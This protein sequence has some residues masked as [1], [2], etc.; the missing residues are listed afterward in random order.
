MA[1]TKA[2][3][4][5]RVDSLVH[6]HLRIEA[7][8]RNST[9]NGVLRRDLGLEEV[10]NQLPSDEAAK[11]FDATQLPKIKWA[12]SKEAQQ[13]FSAEVIEIFQA[14]ANLLNTC[15]ER[16]LPEDVALQLAKLHALCLACSNSHID[17]ELALHYSGIKYEE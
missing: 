5:I 4:K 9:I 10:E 16:E 17:M 8:R 6:R 12:T 11:T 7:A 3:V 2:E 14:I 1:E 13:F 15:W